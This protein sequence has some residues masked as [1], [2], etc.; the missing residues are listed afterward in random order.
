VLA[1]GEVDV[2]VFQVLHEGGAVGGPYLALA[3]VAASTYRVAARF[4]AVVEQIAPVA[5]VV[6]AAQAKRVA[7]LG[8]LECECVDVGLETRIVW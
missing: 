3:V 6:A 4:L 1:G 8:D 5:C 2:V 7:E